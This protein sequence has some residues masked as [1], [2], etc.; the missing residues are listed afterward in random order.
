[1]EACSTERIVL[2]L[3]GSADEEAEILY[4]V[5][6]NSVSYAL[7]R[8]S[9][10]CYTDSNGLGK[11]G[12]SFLHESEVMKTPVHASVERRETCSRTP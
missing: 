7:T 10:P 8:L 5:H 1:M 3:G 4:Y 2:T 11:S 9:Y 6:P 12:P